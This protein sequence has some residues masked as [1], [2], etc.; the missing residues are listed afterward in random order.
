MLGGKRQRL[1]CTRVSSR[2]YTKVR[3]ELL[4]C[5]AFPACYVL[6]Q[7]SLA[8]RFEERQLK[9]IMQADASSRSRSMFLFER[10]FG[11]EK[12]RAHPITLGPAL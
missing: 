11:Y 8:N 9:G 5:K 10:Y 12:C 1:E 6:Y 7:V 4:R 2:S 3:Y